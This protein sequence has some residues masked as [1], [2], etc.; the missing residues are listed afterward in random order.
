MTIKILIDN[1]AEPPLVAEWG[2]SAY[3]EYAD[4]HLLLDT[5]G[6]GKFLQ[7]AEL[8]GV[9]IGNVEFGILSHAH[10]DHSDGMETFFEHNASSVFYLRRSCGENCYSGK[11]HLIPRYIGIKRGL[12]DKYDSRI[13]YVSGDFE[14]IPGAMLI[15]HKTPNL[16]SIG[17]KSKM[18]ISRHGRR[19]FDDF[20]HEQSLV[21]DTPSG[22][23]IL[24]S[25][26][27]AGADNIINEIRQTYPNKS[28]YALVGGLHTHA[29]SPSD[30]RKLAS[31]IFDT[32]IKH[33]YTG[34][35]TGEPAMIILKEVLGNKIEQFYS[36]MEI[37]I[38]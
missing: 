6:S 3:I 14:I 24:N 4:R 34:H 2:F 17:K 27:H 5:G 26:C 25:C 20:S 33:V 15:P 9:N 37:S 22:L 21:L 31:G 23:V 19:R 10:Y 11:K 35:C 8:L 28:I 7:N 18:Y 12:L 38:P 16:E 29:S 36:G 13:F 1:H 32:G 30:V